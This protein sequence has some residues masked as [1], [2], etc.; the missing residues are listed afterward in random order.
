M[1]KESRTGSREGQEERDTDC[2][3][4]KKMS[5]SWQY[6]IPTEDRFKERKDFVIT[7]LCSFGAVYAGRFDAPEGTGQ[8]G[9][10]REY[11]LWELDGQ[12]YHVN[13]KHLAD[14]PFIVVEW[15]DSPAG[16]FKGLKPIPYDIPNDELERFLRTEVGI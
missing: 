11:S 9:D 8:A 15:A 3:E 12:Y 1:R 10:G 5:G 6:A 7:M 16:P 2:Q 14:K 13:E 4:E